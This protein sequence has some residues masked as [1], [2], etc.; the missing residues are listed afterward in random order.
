MT[1]APANTTSISLEE[2][3]RFY[4]GGKNVF[5]KAVH[6]I[7]ALRNVNLSIETGEIFGLV[8]ESGSGKTTVARLIVGLEKPDTGIIRWR[9]QDVAR[10]RGRHLNQ[11]RQKVQMIFQDPY[12][13]LNPY[14]S[15]RSMIMEPLHIHRRGKR[16]DRQAK[17]LEVL[18]QVGLTPPEMFIGRYPHQLSGGQRQRVAIARALVLDPEILIADE[19]TSMLDAPIAVQIYRILAEIQ[20]QLRITMLFITHH[21][22][23]AHYL[24]NRIAVIYHGH[25]VEV[26]P[27]QA[28]IANPHHPYT[29]ALIDALPRF[30]HL[31]PEQRFNTLRETEN[32]VPDSD[33]CP[34]YTRCAPAD[35]DQCSKEFPH[36]QEVGDRHCVAC[37]FQK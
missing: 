36:M 35:D 26:G 31:R 19:P 11:F 20:K 18:A 15:V 30:G 22:A 33:C 34:F 4:E 1:D 14:Q 9:G 23:A 12:Q 32:A 16:A 8:G 10:L 13:S 24:C 6:N 27:A 37:F 29:R 17:I 21:L 2:V 5:G 28:V 25:I 3:S 7:I